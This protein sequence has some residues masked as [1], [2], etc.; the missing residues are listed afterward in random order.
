MNNWV[1]GGVM[2]VSICRFGDHV[3]EL[4]WALELFGDYRRRVVTLPKVSFLAQE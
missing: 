3:E 1:G 2:A 4:G